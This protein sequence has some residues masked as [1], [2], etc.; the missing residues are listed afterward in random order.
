[1]LPVDEEKFDI[2]YQSWTLEY[3]MTQ[4]VYCQEYT[5]EKYVEIL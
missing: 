4:Q 1:M 5:Q 2:H 3:S